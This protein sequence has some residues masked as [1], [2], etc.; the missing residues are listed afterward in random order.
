MKKVLILSYYF[1]PCNLTPSERI[2]SWAKYL[3]KFGIYPIIITRNWDIPIKAFS[4]E[5]KPSGTEPIHAVH[6]GYE[7]WYMPYKQSYK[8]SLFFK[9]Q[10]V[11]YKWLYLVVSLW[12]NIK[13]AFT[14]SDSPMNIIY[15]KADEL[16]SKDKSI[17]LLLASAYPYA[18]FEYCHLLHKKYNTK[19]IADYRDDWTS[20]EILNRSTIHRILNKLNAINEKKWL[21]TAS[22]FLTVSEYYVEK[23][24]RVV[25]NNVP[26]HCIL[27]GYMTENYNSLIT[28]NASSDYKITYVGSLYH[29]QPIELFLN[30]AK[31][32]ID[33]HKPTNFNI[34]FVGLK[35][36]QEAYNR[37]FNQIT[38]YEGYFTFTERIAKAEAIQI[39]YHSNLLLICTHPGM[40]GTPG[41]KLYEYI[42][43]KKLVMMTPSDEDIVEQT[44]TET[45]QAIVANTSEEVSKHIEQLYLS[46]K[47]QDNNQPVLNEDA[48][49]K[50]DRY[51]QT[52]KLGEIIN[53]ILN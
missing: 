2:Y 23:I 42:A 53:N 28:T 16:L 26:G 45:N 44:L 5:L 52:Q 32:F 29:T 37:V 17:Q 40:K 3:N 33:K 13:Q 30:G 15:K 51:H 47:N 31:L 4:D 41:S 19:W 22:C 36:N 12:V 50:Y 9:Q 39:Q 34:T 48:I 14:F 21:A 8:E 43:L 25:G 24:Q 20:N 6:D 18:L 27:N 49:K 35:N 7:V 38:G 1:P 11:F 46:F 10:N